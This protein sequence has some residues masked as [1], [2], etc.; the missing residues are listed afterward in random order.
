MITQPFSALLADQFATIDSD[1]LTKLSPSHS[2]SFASPVLAFFAAIASLCMRTCREAD[3]R[4][5]KHDA[6]STCRG[7]TVHLATAAGHVPACPVQPEESPAQP[8][9]DKLMA[10]SWPC[11]RMT[12]HTPAP[13]GW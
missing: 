2:S 7:L 3:T 12:V 4:D 1:C 11:V 10:T 13:C 6:G 5:G 9:C 8:E